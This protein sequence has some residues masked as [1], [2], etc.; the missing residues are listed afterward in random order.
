MG[1]GRVDAGDGGVYP[2]V[3]VRACVRAC[4]LACA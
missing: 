4:L 2:Y 1:S 3:S